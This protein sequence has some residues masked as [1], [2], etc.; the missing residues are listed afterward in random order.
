[1]IPFAERKLRKR[2]AIPLRIPLVLHQYAKR[3]TSHRVLQK[4]KQPQ[5]PKGRCQRA[6]KDKLQRGSRETFGQSRPQ[7]RGV[8]HRRTDKRN[9]EPEEGK[10]RAERIE[11]PAHRRPDE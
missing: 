9:R 7:N 11:E 6:Y 2:D 3:L 4:L 5:K 8:R 10:Q 1:M